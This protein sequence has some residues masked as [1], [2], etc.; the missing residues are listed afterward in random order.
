LKKLSSRIGYPPS[1]TGDAILLVLFFTPWVAAPPAIIWSGC[2]PAKTRASGSGSSGATNTARELGP[3]AFVL[4]F[5]IDMGK[6][7]GRLG[8]RFSNATNRGRCLRYRSGR[9]S[10]LARSVGVAR[11]QKGSPPP[12]ARCSS[13]ITTLLCY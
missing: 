5:V 7:H 10:H 2:A 6:E 13:S 8:Q 12:W 4:T 11:R 1:I 9:G 3:W